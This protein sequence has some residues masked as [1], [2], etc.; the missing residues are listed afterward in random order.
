MFVI[1]Y[2]NPLHAVRRAME[3]A[4]L[5]KITLPCP[6]RA[7]AV[8]VGPSL[9]L[10]FVPSNVNKQRKE[11]REKYILGWAW[12]ALLSLRSRALLIGPQ[13]NL[14]QTRLLPHRPEEG[15]IW[16]PTHPGVLQKL[17][18]GGCRSLIPKEEADGAEGALGRSH[19]QSLSTLRHICLISG[20][21]HRH[22]MKRW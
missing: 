4:G 18:Q 13:L 14:L 6:G 17:Q 22:L 15:Q 8:I 2:L 12:P 9:L 16:H 11:T 20:I 21:Q 5:S 19:S 7:R 10:P 1:F 3:A